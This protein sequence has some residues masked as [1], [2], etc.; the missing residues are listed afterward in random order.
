MPGSE[1]VL[2]VFISLVMFCTYEN[3]GYIYYAVN[4]RAHSFWPKDHKRLYLF[5]YVFRNAIS[6]HGL[7]IIVC[8]I[9][10]TII[11]YYKSGVVKRF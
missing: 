10:P 1:I 4:G 2:K 9:Y 6:V 11:C 3:C 8:R 5:I 7:L